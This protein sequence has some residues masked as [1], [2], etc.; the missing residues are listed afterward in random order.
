M[1]AITIKW[2][3]PK[4]IR[5]GQPW[6]SLDRVLLK[7]SIENDSVT[8]RLGSFDWDVEIASAAQS[9]LDRLGWHEYAVSEDSIVALDT[10]GYVDPKGDISWVAIPQQVQ[11][12]R[13]SLN[14]I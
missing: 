4:R 2:V 6:L 3:R 12:S 14:N 8:V 5:K 7:A 10:R 1:K 13:V 9:L 11:D